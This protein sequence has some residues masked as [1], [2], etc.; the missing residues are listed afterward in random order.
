MAQDTSLINGASSESLG[1]YTDGFFALVGG[2]VLGF[3]FNWQMSLVCL[4]LTPFLVV[5]QYVGM[6]F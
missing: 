5:G 4:A 2:L 6:E 3:Y 1:P